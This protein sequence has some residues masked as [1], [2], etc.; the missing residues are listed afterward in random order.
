MSECSTLSFYHTIIPKKAQPIRPLQRSDG[1]GLLSVKNG[2]LQKMRDRW[3]NC[4]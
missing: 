4:G 3:K 2:R 1:L